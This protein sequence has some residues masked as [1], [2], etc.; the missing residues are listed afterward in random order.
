MGEEF[1]QLQKNHIGDPSCVK[2]AFI[3][4]LLLSKCGYLLHRVS[5]VPEVA[6]LYSDTIKYHYSIN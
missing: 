4:M 3:D 6:L 1:T 5:N 2:D